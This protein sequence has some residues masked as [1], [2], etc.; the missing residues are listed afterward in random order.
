MEI[1]REGQKLLAML[2]L[3]I[4]GA[5]AYDTPFGPRVRTHELVRDSMSELRDPQRRLAHELWA[6]LAVMRASSP[7]DTS[8]LARPAAWPDAFAALGWRKR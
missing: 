5:H 6:R 8:E 3:D 2:D 4:A 7:R 1:E